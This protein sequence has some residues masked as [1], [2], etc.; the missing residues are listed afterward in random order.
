MVRDLV[1]PELSLMFS[2]HCNRGSARMP[3]QVLGAIKKSVPFNPSISCGLT[4]VTPVAC[5]FEVARLS[6]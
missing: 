3:F 5:G 6:T 2:S 1:D 4:R